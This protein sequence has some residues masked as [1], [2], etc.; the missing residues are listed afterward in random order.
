MREF[1]HLFPKPSHYAGLEPGAVHKNPASVDL[2]IALAFPDAYTVGM[3]YLGQKI[4]YGIANAR[5]NWHAERVMAPEREVCDFLRKRSI[6]LATLETGTPLKDMAAVCFSVTHELCYTDVL[7]MLD[8]AGI[9]LRAKDRPDS[10]KACPLI[11][12][13]G[14]AM[15]G[16]EPLTPFLDLV[17]LGDGEEQF[18]EILELLDRARK[19]GWGRHKFLQ[20]AR[21]IRGTYVPAF[22]VPD[23]HGALKPVYDDHK[24]ARRIVRD[25]NLAPYPVDQINPVGA[26]H[27]RL[28]LEIARGC[29]RGCRFCHAGMTYRPVRERSPAVA[30]RLLSECLART[31]FDEVSF[32]ALSAG[33]CTALKTIYSDAFS[34][35]QRQ[36]TTLAL[37]SL[38]VGSIDDDIMAKMA[39]IRRPG[40]TL[41]PEAGSQRLRDVI[42]KGVTEADLLAHCAKL[43]EYGW[44]Q[45]KLYFMI[46]LPTETDDDLRAIMDLCEKARNCG[47]KGAPRLQITAAVS[48]FVPKPFTPFQWTGQINLPEMERRIALLR[49]LCKKGITL[50]WHNPEASHL[51]GILSRGDRRLADVVE[52][53]F[54]KG[55]IFCGWA[56]N[57]SLAPWQEA[58]AECGLA[59]EAYTG[60]RDPANP[61]PWDHLNGGITREFLW[62]E[63]QNALQ[64]RSTPDCRFHGCRNCGACDIPGRKSLLGD[65]GPVTHRLAFASRDQE[66]CPPNMD[67]GGKLLLRQYKKEPPHI[68]RQL[69]QKATLLRCWHRKTGAQAFLSHLE[70]ATLLA[71]TFRKASLPVSFSQGYHPLPLLSFG[72]AMP[73]GMESQAEWFSIWLRTP[74]TPQK[75]MHQLNAWLPPGL[76][77]FEVELASQRVEMAVAET[78]RLGLADAASLRQAAEGFARF[79]GQDEVLIALQTKKGERQKN[80]R[81]FL[82]NW[83]ATDNAIELSTDWSEDYI[84]PLVLVKSIL[85]PLSPE[86]ERLELT[87]TG[88]IFLSGK[89]YGFQP[90][91]AAS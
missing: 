24:P 39:S 25:L 16:A 70:L 42:N 46:G 36:Q 45:V 86:T 85:A 19:A 58:M 9:P 27:D 21:H 48:P 18:P 52:K 50:K 56:E 30:S 78:Y 10:L 43:L 68:D 31:G 28:S 32:L 82:L 67:E 84:S 5:P 69:I 80:I 91:F 60:A 89:K 22:F 34:L 63:W 61:L 88:Q 57:F 54:R 76:R 8:L 1:L 77:V 33:D 4:L 59:P 55:A 81:P 26:V 38:R 64:A 51:E 53:A 79:T 14:G 83:Q 37:P 20:E 2:R 74:T 35:C 12:A 7:N 3:S 15:L 72:R 75:A 44:R 23:D 49:N 65:D 13:G 11:L 87:K 71:R 66:T 62:R 17:S 73:V 47:G 90:T 40:C 29:A 6:P 41:A